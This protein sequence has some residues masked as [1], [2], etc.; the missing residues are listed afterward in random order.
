MAMPAP[1]PQFTIEMLDAMPQAPGERYELVDGFL[2]VTPA[3]APMHAKLAQ[4]LSMI[5]GAAIPESVASVAQVGEIR[6]GDATSLQPDILIYPSGS[7]TPARWRDVT[8]WWLAVEIVSPSSRLYDREHKRRAYLALGVPVYWVV[9]TESRTIEVWRP[10][11]AAPRVFHDRF[12]WT[13]PSGHRVEIAL[14]KLFADTP[15]R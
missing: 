10:G 1:A 15:T 2:I 6:A 3:A 12:D 14:D 5:L 9:D 13:P 8:S 11:D 7:S 4:R